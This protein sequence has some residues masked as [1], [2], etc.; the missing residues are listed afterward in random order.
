MIIQKKKKN[1]IT[2]N[3]SYLY[4]PILASRFRA[5][6]SWAKQILLTQIGKQC[7][8]WTRRLRFRNMNYK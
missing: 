6:F 1:C 8:K 5:Y 2:L 7:V 3:I 4:R